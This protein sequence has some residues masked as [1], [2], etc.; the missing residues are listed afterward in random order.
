MMSTGCMRPITIA[1]DKHAKKRPCGQ[2]PVCRQRYA[3]GWAVR[4][5]NEERSSSTAHFITFTYATHNLSMSSS[6]AQTL[7]KSHLQKFFKRLRQCNVRR[8]NLLPIKYYAVGEYGSKTKRPHYHALIFNCHVDTIELAWSKRSHSM[9]QPVSIGEIHY[10]DVTPASIGY[11]LKY[12]VKPKSVPHP[13]VAQY[14]NDDRQREFS[15]ISNGIGLSYLTDN[16][17]SW[18]LADLHNRRYIVL[19]DGI[20]AAMPRYYYEKIYDGYQRDL[21]EMSGSLISQSEF[22]EQFESGF[23]STKEYKNEMRLY[24]TRVEAAF[25]RQSHKNSQTL[26]I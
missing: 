25:C 10:G 23:L 19:P 11:T 12:M 8:G 4:L 26:K 20:K 7:V 18:H 6:G 17:K 9:A 3:A 16:M 21:M 2:C 14:Y 1:R 24:K 15:L 5:Q 13:R 22:F